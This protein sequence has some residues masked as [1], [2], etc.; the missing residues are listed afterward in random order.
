M[1]KYLFTF[2]I[3]TYAIFLSS[4][5][6][7]KRHYV[8]G[9]YVGHN[10]SKSV[11]NKTKEQISGNKEPQSLYTMQNVSDNGRV[12]NLKLISATENEGIIASNTSNKKITNKVTPAT[13]YKKHV[14]YNAE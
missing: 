6:L 14:G 3:I 8:S 12:D 1:K 13:L 11:T 10:S 4:C 5:S 7:V 2:A 9:Y